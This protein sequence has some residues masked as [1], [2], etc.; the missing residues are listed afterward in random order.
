MRKT[1]TFST[2][3]RE[4]LVDITAQ[5]QAVLDESGIA[6]F[7][8]ARFVFGPVSLSTG[9][10]ASILGAQPPRRFAHPARERASAEAR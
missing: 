4:I 5:V 6:Q 8:V 3:E 1:I 10:S 7:N 2:P 9:P